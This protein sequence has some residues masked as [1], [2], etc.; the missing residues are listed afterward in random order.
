MIKICKI[1]TGSCHQACVCSWGP[2]WLV[3]DKP[4]CLASFWIH[5]RRERSTLTQKI[6]MKSSSK[7]TFSATKRVEEK[8]NFQ[9]Q[10]LC[11]TDGKGVVKNSTVIMTLI[12]PTIVW[13]CPLKVKRLPSPISWEDMV[14]R[15]AAKAVIIPKDSLP[16]MPVF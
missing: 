13:T 15:H 12:F 8:Y 2:Q 5:L 16:K 9:F 7:G 4:H 10:Y 6:S 11:V 1:V 14:N 3:S